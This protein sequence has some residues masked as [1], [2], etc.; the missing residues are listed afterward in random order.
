MRP[1]TLSLTHTKICALRVRFLRNMCAPCPVV[2]RLAC[3]VCVSH[4]QDSSMA[5]FI[6]FMYTLVERYSCV[7]HSFYTLDIR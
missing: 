6:Y 4:T 7:T 3:V 1:C 2:V 5:L